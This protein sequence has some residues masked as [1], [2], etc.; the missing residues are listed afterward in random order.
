MIQLALTTRNRRHALAHAVPTSPPAV[1]RPVATLAFA[2]DP[3]RIAMFLLTLI[4]ISRVHE[5]FPILMKARPGLL[6]VAATAT[7]AFLNRRLLTQVNVFAYWPMRATAI[8]A[9]LA[10]CSAVFGISL[11]GSA[12]YILDEYSRTLVYCALLALSIRGVRDLYTFMWAVALS[13]GILSF[14][15]LFVFQLETSVGSAVARLGNMN[16]YDA[17]DMCVVLLFGLAAVLLLLQVATGPRKYLLLAII[18]GVGAAIARSGSRGGFVGLAVFGLAALLLVN[19]VSVAKRVGLLL[20]VG[21]GIALFAPP[22][23]W[24]QM[25]TILNPEEDYNLHSKDGRKQLILRGLRYMSAYPVFGVGISNF[26]KAECDPE[27]SLE[28]TGRRG[29]RCG[30][31]HNSYIQAGAEAGPLGLL[32]WMSLAPGGALLLLRLRSRL[33]RRWRRGNDVERFLYGGTHFLAAGVIGFSASAFFVSFAWVDLVYVQA[34]LITGLFVSVRAY[35]TSVSAA[36][37]AGLVAPRAATRRGPG[38]RV[39]ESLQRVGGTAPV[40]ARQRLA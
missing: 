18:V 17:N 15:A 40:S 25:E 4:N 32:V 37:A 9:A 1:E 8:L 31:P 30:A 29:V 2:H 14:F 13:C 6:L 27:L 7:Y 16:T 35:R 38:W 11:G 22:G 20:A 24:K 10:C 19:S 26:G 5:Q 21:L 23:Y 33:P 36:T 28:E 3:L 34:A 12:R 39:R